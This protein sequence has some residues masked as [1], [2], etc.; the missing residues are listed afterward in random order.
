MF[1]FID[2]SSKVTPK[3]SGLAYHFEVAIPD[4]SPRLKKG[5]RLYLLFANYAAAKAGLHSASRALA[6]EVASRGVTVN[7]VAPGVIA[8]PMTEQIFTPERID[9]LLWSP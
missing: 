6:L 4:G 5:G 8:S 7:V 9:A 1:W 2:A 3:F